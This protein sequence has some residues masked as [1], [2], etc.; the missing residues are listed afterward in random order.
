MKEREMK[1]RRIKIL[2]LLL[3]LVMVLGV[4][5]G[6]AAYA[7]EPKVISKDVEYYIGDTIQ[8]SSP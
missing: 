5:P 8:F 2:A 7:A 4:L 3:G 6:I 1:D